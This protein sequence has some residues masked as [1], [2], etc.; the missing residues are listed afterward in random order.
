MA[1][2]KTLDEVRHVD[3][4]AILHNGSWCPRC[5]KNQRFTI[6]EI[7]LIA[8]GRGGECLSSTY[9]NIYEKLEWRCQS[10]HVWLAATNSIKRGGW[11]PICY[12]ISRS[13]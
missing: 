1:R 2:A 10:G 9:N 13:K 6:E 8:A 5:N 12:K 11:C 7:K 3:G 4:A